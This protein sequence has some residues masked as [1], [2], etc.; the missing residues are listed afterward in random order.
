MNALSLFSSAGIAEYYLK[1]LGIDVVLANEL[2]KKRAETHKSIY[3]DCEIINSD[4]T[5]QE[6]RDLIVSKCKDKNIDLI[7]VTPPC[8]GVST[9]GKNKSEAAIYQ[10]SR[11][12]LVLSA[13][14]V[15]DKVNPN[16]FLIENVPRFQEMKFPYN[17]DD[18][19]LE[20]LLKK[21]YG[22]DY[23]IACDIFNAAD[24]GVPQT[25]YRIVYR[26]W[27]YDHTW[28]LPKKQKEITLKDAIG[29][30]PSLEAGQKSK[31]K[32]HYARKH[33]AN[34]IQCMKYTP[35]G[36]SAFKNEIHYPRKSD[37]TRIKGYGNSYKRMRWD[38]PAPT[39]T[40]R[41][42][43]ISSQENVHPGREL[44]DGTWSDARILT[45]RELLIVSSLPADMDRPTNISETMFRQL[46]GEGVPP[47]MLEEIMKGIDE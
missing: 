8:Q 38:A 4:I 11:N 13:L 2:V 47:K 36:K 5:K 45:L 12:F 22:K 6:T 26:A 46:I 10:D 9:V 16:F 41:N 28:L 34:H 7:I 3:P 35:T 20:D 27:K 17:G 42:E 18:L 19:I 23:M 32:N 40:M 33:A 44:L 25:R 30:L 21:R 29:D 37:G 31:I 24:Y 14:E 39:I 1:N 43:I 15:I